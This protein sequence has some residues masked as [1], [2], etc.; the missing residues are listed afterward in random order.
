MQPDSP[1]GSSSL[2][3][4]AEPQVASVLQQRIALGHQANSAYQRPPVPADCNRGRPEPEQQVAERAAA[5]Q[6][7]RGSAS[8][9]AHVHALDPAEAPTPGA[10]HAAKHAADHP[11]AVSHQPAT[12]SDDAGSND[13]SGAESDGSGSGGLDSQDPFA[14]GDSDPDTLSDV[15]TVASP[16]TCVTADFAMQNVLL[17]M[18]LQLQ[19]PNGLRLKHVSRFAQRCSACFFVIKVNP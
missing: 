8:D 1:L 13:S 18:G 12:G 7:G 2:A 14:R 11:V 6:P 9:S 5:A 16:I 19:A 15:V 10:S 3:G 4:P 17:Q